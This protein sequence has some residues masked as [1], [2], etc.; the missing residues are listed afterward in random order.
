MLTYTPISADRYFQVV[1]SNLYPDRCPGR[2]IVSRLNPAF[3]W[4]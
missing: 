2:L 3:A 4:C 1:F